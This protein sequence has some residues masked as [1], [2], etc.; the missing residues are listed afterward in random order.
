PDYQSRIIEQDSADYIAGNYEDFI[1]AWIGRDEPESIDM[2]EPIRIISS[3]LNNHN[4]GARPLIM[5]LPVSWNGRFGDEIPWKNSNYVAKSVEFVK[6][7]KN[8]H[9][10]QNSYMFDSPF[11]VNGVPGWV[12]DYK[13]WNIRILGDSILSRIN[14]VDPQFGQ[15]ILCGKYDYNLPN[16]SFREITPYEFAYASHLSLLYG[17]KSLVL[18]SYFGNDDPPYPNRTGL[19]NWDFGA[20]NKTDKFYYVKN[21]LSPRLK[22]LFGKTLKKLTP[23]SQVLNVPL[24]SFLSGSNF[25]KTIIKGGCTAQGMQPSDEAYDLGFFKDAQDGDYFMLISRWYNPGCNPSLTVKIKPEYYLNYNLR[26]VD[27]TNNQTFNTNR[28]GSISTAPV[29][30]DASFFGV[31]P[32]L[33]YGGSI[34]ANDTTYNNE[35]LLDDLTIVNGAT[36]TINGT[37]NANAN[38]TVKSGG[39]IVAGQNATINFG[40]GKK[41]IVEGIVEVKGTSENNNLT[42]VAVTEQAILVKSGSAFTL[43]YCT[44]LAPHTGIETETGIQSYLNVSNTRITANRTGISLI[45][46]SQENRTSSTPPSMIYKCNITTS[47]FYGIS[48][49]NFTSI[50]VKENTLVSCGMSISNVAA[51]YIQN[52]NISLGTNSNQSGIFVNN[53]GGYIRSN[54]IKN[55]V[56]GIHLASSSFDI[57]GNVIENNYKHGLY[58]GSRSFPNLVGLIQTNPPTYYPLAGYNTIRNNGNDTRSGGENDG[59]EIYFNYSDAHLGTERNPGCNQISD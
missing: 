12:D 1:K 45:G 6:R 4:Q 48:V 29:V 34:I 32:V 56:N 14:K 3:V 50:L 52:N 27:Y 36:L 59:S 38:I 47:R 42:I 16:V 9:I 57:G 49:A 23:T 7:T 44:I 2:F 46:G 25:I 55:R 28:F 35:T 13:D 30:G 58:I 17:A 19:V 15:L 40:S 21:I 33:K 20:K 43:N 53:S 22:G 51:A 10:W 11:K 41:L 26:V 54:T 37:Y 5:N 18:F 8:I 31:F 39:K 24:N